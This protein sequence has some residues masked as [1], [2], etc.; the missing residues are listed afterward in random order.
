MVQHW[1]IWGR[2]ING[3]VMKCFTWWGPAEDGIARARKEA[4]DFDYDLDQVWA[5]QDLVQAA[6]NSG[7][8][9]IVRG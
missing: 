5:E 7:K 9:I 6:I 4:K 3:N 2:K 8:L 1:T